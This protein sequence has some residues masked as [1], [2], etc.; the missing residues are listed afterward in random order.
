LGATI[1]ARQAHRLPTPL[2]KRVVC[3]Y[4][5]VVGVWMVVEGLAEAEHSLVEP[6]GWMR[7]TLAAVVGFV[8]AVASGALGVVGPISDSAAL[9][10]RA[11]RS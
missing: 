11:S 5:L 3:V 1:G 10:M 7:W 8:I 9:S 6:A 2:L 4:L